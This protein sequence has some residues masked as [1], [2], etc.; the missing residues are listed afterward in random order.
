MFNGVP[1]VNYQQTKT[2][3]LLQLTEKL[4]QNNVFDSYLTPQQIVVLEFIVSISLEDKRMQIWEEL[5][6]GNL[7]LDVQNVETEGQLHITDK[8]NTPDDDEHTEVNMNEEFSQFDLEDL[9]QTINGEAFVGNLSLKLR[10]VLWQYAIEGSKGLDSATFDIDNA[11]PTN[12]DYILLDV[13]EPEQ[14]ENSGSTEPGEIDDTHKSEEITKPA[15][16]EDEDYDDDDDYDM[17]DKDETSKPSEG[18]TKDQ[19]DVATPFSLEK[20]SNDKS[21]LTMQISN[22]TLTRLRSTN[23]NGILAN[24]TNIY[25]NFEYDRETMLKRLRLE[26]DDE[27][28]ETGKR[29]RAHKDAD[30]TESEKDNAKDAQVKQEDSEKEPNDNEAK[31]GKRPKQDHTVVAPNLGIATLSIKHLL[32]AIQENKSRLDISD[33]ELKHLLVDVR[34]NRSKWASDENIGQEELYD[35]CEKVVQ[36][37]RNYTEHSTPFLNKV[38][39]REAPNYH[40]VIKKSMDLNTVL[41]KLK[42]F[43]YKSK[44]EFVDDVMLIWKN[45]LTYNSDPSHFMRAHAIA[46]QKKSMQLIPMIPN[47]TIRKRADVEKEME[48]MEKDKDYEEEGDEEVAGSGRKGLNMGAHKPANPA[49]EDTKEDTPRDTSVG[50]PA[51]TTGVPESVETPGVQEGDL[52][53]EDSA[54]PENSE[55]LSKDPSTEVNLDKKD[56]SQDKSDSKPTDLTSSDQSSDQKKSSDDNENTRDSTILKTDE[57]ASVLTPVEST[58]ETEDN[59]NDDNDEDEDDDDEDDVLNNQQAYMM[60]RDD[61]KEDIEMST[62]KSLTAK[63]RAEICLKR[64]EYFKNDV[65][66]SQAGALLKN[67]K[68]MKPFEVLFNEF[69]TQRELELYRQQLE[70]QS[71]MKGGFG[72]SV[73]TEEPDSLGP[74][75]PN[76]IEANLI[77]KGANEIDMDNTTFLQE[78]DTNNLYPDIIYEGI[79]KEDLDK[80]EDIVIDM[81]LK[82]GTAKQ[83]SYLANIGRGLTPKLNENISMIQQIRHICHKISLIRLLQSPHY[84]QNQ[85]N[86][87]AGALLRAHQYKYDDIND[88]IDIDPVSQLPTHDFHNDKNLIRKFMHKN[89]SKLAMTNGF[90]TAEPTAIDTLTSLAGEYMSNLIKT[91]K[92]HTESQS[93]NKNSNEEILKL[94]LLE[95]GIDRP[96]DLFT[97][98]EKEFDKKPR[99]LTDVKG[100]LENFLKDLLRPTLQELSER[101]FEDESQSFVTGDFATELTGEDFFGFKDL[102]LEKEFGVLSSSVPLQML[103]SQF[104]VADGETKEQVKKLQPE[105]FEKIRYPRISKESIDEGRFPSTLLPS[106]RAAYERSK[107]YATKPPKGVTIDEKIKRKETNPDAPGYI[108]LEDD[109]VTFKTKGAARLRLPPTGKIN[110]NYKKRLLSDAFILPEQP[111]KP[112]EEPRLDSAAGN[113]TGNGDNSFLLS[114]NEP[115]SSLPLDIPTTTGSLSFDSSSLP[116]STADNSG[117]FS[118]SLPKIEEK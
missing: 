17:D 110:T 46:M 31:D 13:E 28:I 9:K 2:G 36:E 71:L 30:E 32:S 80:Q 93:L 90:E 7:S 5:M 40:Q 92:V 57:D 89:V 70:Q 37:L 21:V 106:L 23:I 52:T 105:E 76:T 66:N 81:A 78:Y 87:N 83:S 113:G 68:K 29:K 11:E 82:E 18:E 97:Y 65:L 79:D 25:H 39:K 12:D 74:P 20:D 49:I 116:T 33:Y 59:V 117:S 54:V 24:W 100:K 51:S 35:A 102:G 86:G 75:G 42:T 69:K 115:S 62:W 104:Q 63:V 58:K 73:K 107:L 34:K 43:Q 103:S 111:E 99:K 77:D 26:E 41:K 91:I 88:S 64:S 72:T 101:N 61:D 48:D 55:V 56:T 22:D 118:L 4:L 19:T 109:E 47:I 84:L 50:T 53:K 8:N 96:D 3:P 27:L 6:N 60:E 16:R 114:Q 44:Q 112:K 67:P 1:I 98:L 95:N 45:C 108:L 85:K 15:A 94:S 14:T 38:S 10:Y